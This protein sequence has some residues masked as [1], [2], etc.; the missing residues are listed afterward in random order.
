M[1]VIPRTHKAAVLH[2]LKQPYVVDHNR[3]VP[4]LLHEW[5]VLVKSHVIGLNPIDWKAPYVLM[6]HAL[7]FLFLL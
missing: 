4:E 6:H 5:E 3:P 1:D 7:S 2:S